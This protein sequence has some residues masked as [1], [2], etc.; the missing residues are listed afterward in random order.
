MHNMTC[1]MYYL[2]NGTLLN[3]TPLPVFQ[4]HPHPSPK[5]L[6]LICHFTFLSCQTAM[7]IP[8]V[9]PSHQVTLKAISKKEAK[10]KE[11][12]VVCGAIYKSSI[13]GIYHSHIMHSISPRALP[14]IPL[15][16]LSF[17]FL[18]HALSLVIV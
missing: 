7:V 4:C 5:S 6:G 8:A 11:E 12:S 13:Q 14:T 1:D 10:G 17:F 3:T 18:T 15:Y 16:S 2:N 9:D